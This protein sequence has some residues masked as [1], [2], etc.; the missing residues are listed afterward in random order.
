MGNVL[1]NYDFDKIVDQ[2]IPNGKYNDY[3]KK[4]LFHSKVWERLELGAIDKET[5]RNIVSYYMPRNWDAYSELNCL[6]DSWTSGMEKNYAVWDIVKHL[7]GQGYR[8][9]ILSNFIKEDFDKL[10]VLDPDFECFEKC[11]VS[12]DLREMKPSPLV[13]RALIVSHRI[14][15]EET[16]FI[17][18]KVENVVGANNEG[19]GGIPFDNAENL[20]SFL[21]DILSYS[22]IQ[23]ERER[24]LRPYQ[25]IYKSP[26]G[27]RK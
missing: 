16:V 18:D 21:S 22:H 4:Y 20:K 6:L 24:L 26:N 3:Y 5:A 17:D 23:R 1:Y 13:Y 14:K 25:D 7:W 11:W 15:P 8:L 12:S 19:I 9:F 10:W 27:L 2:L